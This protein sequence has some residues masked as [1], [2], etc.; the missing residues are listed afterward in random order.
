LWIANSGSNN[1]TRLRASDG[2]L[3]GTYPVGGEPRGLA[4]DGGHIWVTNYATDS[5]TKLRA[6]DG[7]LVGTYDV[8]NGPRGI[9][10]D[11]CNMW[12]VNGDEANLVEL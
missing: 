3:L 4:F 2:A 8:G 12:V 7:S 9:S 10:F 1:V 6:R 11:G 5:V